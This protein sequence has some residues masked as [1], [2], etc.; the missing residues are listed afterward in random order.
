[1][2]AELRIAFVH[3]PV[4]L[5][6]RPYMHV[7]SSVGSCDVECTFVTVPDDQAQRYTT[8]LYTVVSMDVKKSRSL[9]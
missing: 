2:T 7:P 9:V 4:F 8:L 5:D 3:A 6:G 1:M